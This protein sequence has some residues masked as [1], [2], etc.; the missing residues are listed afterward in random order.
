[1]PLFRSRRDTRSPATTAPGRSAPNAYR[2]T[3]S[4]RC[5]EACCTGH[6][7]PQ[8]QLSEM[9][10][11]EREYRLTALRVALDEGE[12]NERQHLL[13][14]AEHQLT[15][16][17]LAQEMQPLLTQQQQLSDLMEANADGAA[18]KSLS[19]FRDLLAVDQVLR[20]LQEQHQQAM[21]TQQHFEV[22]VLKGV[23]R[24]VG[25]LRSEHNLLLEALHAD[26]KHLNVPIRRR[27]PAPFNGSRSRPANKPTFLTLP[28]LSAHATGIPAHGATP[29]PPE[30]LTWPTLSAPTLDGASVQALEPAHGSGSTH[31]GS[32]TGARQ[33][34]H[35]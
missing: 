1:M 25:R 14:L 22:D 27:P 21:R 20:P 19:I 5:D 28:T 11:V 35:V 7:V 18:D 4:C 29:S 15:V 2:G 34:V 30:F 6:R 33:P 8:R 17:L 3:S 31:A 23:R 10:V 12:V 13:Q 32:H 26:G 24:A 16:D 9:T